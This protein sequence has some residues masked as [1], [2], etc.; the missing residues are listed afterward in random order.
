MKIRVY[1]LLHTCAMPC[2][3]LASEDWWLATVDSELVAI[4]NIEGFC[5]TAVTVYLLM[6]PMW[7]FVLSLILRCW[8]SIP[9]TVIQWFSINASILGFIWYKKCCN[10]LVILKY[11]PSLCTH[12]STGTALYT[13]Y[14]VCTLLCTYSSPTTCAPRVFTV[15]AKQEL[16]AMQDRPALIGWGARFR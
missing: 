5:Q 1:T 15:T 11:C 2:M 14:T 4:Y 10:Y 7:A 9:S 13:H 6:L 3:L 16:A 8:N 12:S